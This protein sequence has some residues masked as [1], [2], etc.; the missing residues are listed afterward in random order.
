LPGKFPRL[1]QISEFKRLI[2]SI[3]PDLVQGWMYHGNFASIFIPLVT[4]RKIPIL[5]SLHSSDYHYTKN[6]IVNHFVNCSLGFFSRL[7][8]RII[9]CSRK[10][11]ET[12][13]KKGYASSRLT[14][15]PNGFD[16]DVFQPSFEARSEFRRRLD[17][18]PEAKLIGLVGRFHP[19]KDHKNF[20]E[21]ALILSKKI[22]GLKFVL[23]GS[24]ID[25]SNLPLVDLIQAKGLQKSVLLLGRQNN[26][27]SLYPGLDILA[28]A[29][30]SEAFSNVIGEAMA[31]GVPCAVT[32]V[33]DS[34]WIVGDTGKVVPP[35]DPEALARGWQELIEEDAQTR[36]R[37]GMAARQRIIENFSLEKVVLQYENLYKGLLCAE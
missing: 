20:F 10:G 3:A 26:L 36:Q 7:P 31:C 13:Q 37:R 16:T 25:P 28:S 15:I 23:A 19:V 27:A 11:V 4:R 29:S 34:A 24:S 21:A 33:G 12:H 35:R 6:K 5:W 14:F 22:S 30:S 8:R 1:H 18:P 32:D 17:L 9:S 2:R